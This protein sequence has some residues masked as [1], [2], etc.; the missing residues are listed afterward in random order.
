MIFKNLYLKNIPYYNYNQ[1][2][3]FFSVFLHHLLMFTIILL[4]MCNKIF[5]SFNLIN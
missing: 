3:T 5:S 4:K 2:L 1:F